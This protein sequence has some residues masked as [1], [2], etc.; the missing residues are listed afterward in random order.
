MLFVSAPPVLVVLGSLLARG[1]VEEVFIISAPAEVLDVPAVALCY[2]FV[3]APAF[4]TEAVRMA[5]P[6]ACTCA[7][8]IPEPWESIRGPP[9]Y[10]SR[11]L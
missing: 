9:N 4:R 10:K 11:P 3:E 5:S 8:V 2:S 6:V 7:G 1:G